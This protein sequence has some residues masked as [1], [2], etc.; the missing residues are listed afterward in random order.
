MIQTIPLSLLV[1]AIYAVAAEGVVQ[2]RSGYL[3]QSRPTRWCL[4]LT[5]T[6]GSLIFLFSVATM[7]VGGLCQFHVGPFRHSKSVRYE[8]TAD[9]G[10]VRIATDTNSHRLVEL[11]IDPATGKAVEA[12]L[13]GPYS[14]F[15]GN[16]NIG[17]GISRKNPSPRLVYGQYAEGSILLRSVRGGGNN[18]WYY[19]PQEGILAGYYTRDGVVWIRRIG[20]DGFLEDGEPV[21]RRFKGS[22]YEPVHT[23]MR[24]HQGNTILP[25]GVERVEPDYVSWSNIL[26][27][28]DGIYSINASSQSVHRVYVAPEDNPLLRYAPCGTESAVWLLHRKTARKVVLSEVVDGQATELPHD[29]N[30][31]LSLHGNLPGY[32]IQYPEAIPESGVRM[33]D[34]PQINQVAYRWNLRWDH[35]LGTR[36]QCVVIATREGEI[37]KQIVHDGPTFTSIDSY[38][39][40]IYPLGFMESYLRLFPGRARGVPVSGVPTDFFVTPP[41]YFYEKVVGLSLLIAAMVTVLI[42]KRARQSNASIL[43]WLLG[44]VIFGPAPSRL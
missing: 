23:L 31:R 41:T 10:I 22:A 13:V 11:M 43:R 8:V 38:F 30:G 16:L 37:V 34:L 9:G 2:H 27:F 28:E 44:N 17:L 3:S 39:A 24:N 19:L 32:E 40:P 25:P 20:P 7:T 5:T 18:S 15:F 6:C 12:P 42:A 21:S 1:T 4:A 36:H 33:F 26:S 14:S 35:R 29:A